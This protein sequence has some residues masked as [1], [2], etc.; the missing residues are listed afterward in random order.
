MFNI[1]LIM[2]IINFYKNI[3]NNFL[4]SIEGAHFQFLSVN[5]HLAVISFELLLNF[6]LSI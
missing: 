4:T 3:L 1:K 2:K 6:N 5:K